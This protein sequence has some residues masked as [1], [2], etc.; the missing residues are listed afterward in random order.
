MTKAHGPLL[1]REQGLTG[2]VFGFHNNTSL[3]GL[4][5]LYRCALA[6]EEHASLMDLGHVGVQPCLEVIQLDHCGLFGSSFE[7]M[8]NKRK[9]VR[10]E[11]E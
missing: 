9:G 3:L 1:F 11:A 6:A 8:V 4:L 2:V 5:G 10:R 7:S